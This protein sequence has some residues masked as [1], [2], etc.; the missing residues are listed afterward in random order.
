[1]VELDHADRAE[2]PHVPHARAA[3]PPRASPSRSPASI[4]LTSCCQSWPSSRSIEAQA[5]AAASGLPM[6]VGPCA[7]TGTS[8]REM[9]SATRGV[10]SVAAIV[11]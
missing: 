4:R 11:R 1:M 7:S 5:T 8:P 9:P 10:H 3:R 6:K 2:H